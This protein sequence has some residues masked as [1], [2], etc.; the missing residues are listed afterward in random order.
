MN[1]SLILREPTTTRAWCTAIA[2]VVFFLYP[3]KHQQQS[4]YGPVV[5]D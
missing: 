1:E 4:A 5:V 2:S 3:Q